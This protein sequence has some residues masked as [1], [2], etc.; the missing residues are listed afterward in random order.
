[1]TFRCLFKGHDFSQFP[2]NINSGTYFVCA[3]YGKAI[4]RSLIGMKNYD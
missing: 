3:K 2:N 4:W 1:M